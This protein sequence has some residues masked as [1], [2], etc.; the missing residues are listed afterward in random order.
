MDQLA[1]RLVPV[2]ALVAD[3]AEQLRQD[4]REVNALFRDLLIN[5]TNFFR[6]AD[7]FDKLAELVIPKLF[8]NRGAEVLWVSFDSPAE[9]AGLDIGDIITSF[10]GKPVA[11]NGDLETLLM[12]RRPG[13]TVEIG[14]PG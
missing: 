10:D 4:P 12:A 2:P 3:E 6:D 5:V 11:S 7:A 13:D 9:V 1:L 8:E 14:W